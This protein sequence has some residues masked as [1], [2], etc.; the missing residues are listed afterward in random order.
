MPSAIEVY[1]GQGAL[2][3]RRGPGTK[4]SK[5]EVNNQKS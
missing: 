1:L 3:M 4:I 5:L 2:G